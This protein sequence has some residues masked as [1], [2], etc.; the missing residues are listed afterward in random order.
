MDVAEATRPLRPEEIRMFREAELAHR[1]VS[2]VAALGFVQENFHPIF[3]DVGGGARQLDIVLQDE[4][5][6][7]LG[8]CLRT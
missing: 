5:G 3:P 6:E 2:M 7:A 8:A 4:N 1:R